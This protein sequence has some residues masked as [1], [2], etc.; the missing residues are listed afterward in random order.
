MTHNP[1]GPDQGTFFLP[2]AIS[3]SEQVVA[4]QRNSLPE[5]L[6]NTTIN[7]GPSITLHDRKVYLLRTLDL[8]SEAGSRYGLAKALMDEGTGQEIHEERGAA[9]IEGYVR[10]RS[11]LWQRDSGETVENRVIRGVFERA[12][13]YET[14]NPTVMGAETDAQALGNRA[15]RAFLRTYQGKEGEK[16]R[17]QLRK[18]LDPDMKLRRAIRR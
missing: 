11:A 8:I 15:L 16:S 12:T 1:I 6:Q 9:A 18:T 7:D 4:E 14:T 2:D 5:A 13:G 17:A 3:L 10:A